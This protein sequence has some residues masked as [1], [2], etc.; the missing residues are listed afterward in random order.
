MTL[1]NLHDKLLK[2][3]QTKSGTSSGDLLVSMDSDDLEQSKV[4]R[5]SGSSEKQTIQFDSEGNPL[6][7]SG[8]LKYIS[9]NRNLDICVADFGVKAVVVVNQSGEFRCRYTGHPS[10]IG[11]SFSPVGIITDSQSKTLTADVLNAAST[12]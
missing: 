10:T 5:Y 7:S 8:N 2:S 9:E 3:I 12:S 1:Y 11:A 4:A 6:Y